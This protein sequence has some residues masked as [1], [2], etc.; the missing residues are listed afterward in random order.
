M[1]T[2]LD[3]YLEI[4]RPKSFVRYTTLLA[5]FALISLFQLSITSLAIETEEATVDV[6]IIDN[7][8]L[9]LPYASIGSNISILSTVT[10]NGLTEK[11]F[12][13]IVQ[14]KDPEDRVIFLSVTPTV[15]GG[16]DARTIE[17]LWLSE[18]EGMHAI[19]IFVWQQIESPLTFSYYATQFQ[20]NAD[21]GTKVECSGSAACF[22]GI[23]TK[24]TDGDTI[25]VD[26]IT[27][28]FALVDTPEI[29]EAGYHEAT[30]FTS[31]LCSVGSEVLVD[32]DD[33][34]TAGSYGR[35]IA[36]VYC[37]GQLINEELLE[38]RNAILLT[39]HCDESEFAHEGWAKKFGC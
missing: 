26:S 35:M 16:T 8:G 31:K 39:R 32:E 18:E 13:Y 9:P 30:S 3:D 33:G 37:D 14:I 29:G 1:G 21:S 28:R 15:I 23:V 5:G 27:V 25:D 36:K 24:V 7:A 11:A 22:N 6:S 2:K 17:T 4:L 20:I 12:S 38:S 19:Q 10:N 34:Q